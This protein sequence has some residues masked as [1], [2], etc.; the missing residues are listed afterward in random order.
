MKSLS[1][2]IFLERFGGQK[3][4]KVEFYSEGEEWDEIKKD[5]QEQ[6]ISYINEIPKENLLL[7]EAKKNQPP[8]VSKGE[9]KII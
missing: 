6:I 8:F 3:F 1:R 9:Y 2:T 5:I 4:E 7:E